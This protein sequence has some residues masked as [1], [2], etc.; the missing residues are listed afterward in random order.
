MLRTSPDLEQGYFVRLEPARH[1]LAFD[2]W[3]RPGDIPFWVELERPLDLQPG[4]PVH[5]TI[6][7]DGSICEVY[8]DEKVAMSARMYD[9]PS[10]Q[11]GVFAEGGQVTFSE[12]TLSEPPGHHP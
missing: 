8:A 7:V 2:A 11:W 12:V 1:R 9:H 4:K 10:G 5:L 6:L 3:P